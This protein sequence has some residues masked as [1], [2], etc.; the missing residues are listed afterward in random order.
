VI[1]VA[2]D[3]GTGAS[4]PT[5]FVYFDAVTKEVIGHGTFTSSYA[6]ADKRIREISEQFDNALDVVLLVTGDPLVCIETTVMMGKGGQTYQKLVGAFVSRIPYNVTI[7]HVFNTTVKK[8]VG[9]SGHAKKDAVAEGVLHWFRDNKEARELIRELIQME[10][11]D[12][13][14]AFAIG[15]AGYELQ[16]AS[17]ENETNEQQIKKSRARKVRR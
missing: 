4:S 12:I 2:L 16:V 9:G 8:L 14:D 7:R 10:Q 15:I 11:W 1:I 3:P 13:L 6:E 5:G 17:K